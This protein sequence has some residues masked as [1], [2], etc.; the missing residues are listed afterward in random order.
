MVMVQWSPNLQEAVRAAVKKGKSFDNANIN[1]GIVDSERRML[2]RVLSK[3]S[4]QKVGV[5]TV[6]F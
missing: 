2:E 5:A 4:V 1:Y 6:W 3:P